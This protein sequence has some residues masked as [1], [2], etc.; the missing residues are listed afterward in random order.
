[1]SSSKSS[2]DAEGSWSRW[3][4]IPLTP[5]VMLAVSWGLGGLIE[6]G[7][8]RGPRGGCVAADGYEWHGWVLFLMAMPSFVVVI[9]GLVADRWPPALGLIVGGSASGLY[10]LAHGR[11]EPYVIAAGV[12]FILAAVAPALSWHRQRGNPLS[13]AV[14]RLM[15]P[16]TRRGRSSRAGSGKTGLGKG[17]E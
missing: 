4:W 11:T 9:M 1:M 2:F 13:R 7:C 3:W 15:S 16:A 14:R 6:G 17:C 8:R 12:F 5:V 10:M